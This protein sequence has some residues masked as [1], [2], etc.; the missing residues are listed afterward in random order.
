MPRYNPNATYVDDNFGTY[1]MEDQ[2]DC[3]FYFQVQAESVEKECLGCE[4]KV[5]L[6]PDYAYC[7]SCATKREQGWDI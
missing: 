1:E 6:R 2:D 7:N 5:M 4:R 3:D